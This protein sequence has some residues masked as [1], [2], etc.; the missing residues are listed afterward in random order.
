MNTPKNIRP[1]LAALAIALVPHITRLPVWVVLWCLVS[2]GYVLAAVIYNLPQ[3]GKAV[4]LALT[5][6]GILG[7]LLFREG[8]LDQ[9]SSV[10]LLWIMASI[11]PMEIRSRRDEMVIIFMT[12]F[13]AVA[14]LFF[15][16]TL[17]TAV[18]MIFSICISMAVLIR[19]HHPGGRRMDQLRLAAGLILKAMPLALILFL[20]FPRIHGSLWGMRRPTQAYSGFSDSLSPGTVTSLVRNTAIAFRVEF[21]NTIPPPEHLYWRGLVFWHFDGSA[22]HRSNSSLRISLPL[23]GSKTAAYTVT[24]EPHN[25]RW[26]FALDV[27][28]EFEASAVLMSDHTLVSRWRVR[29]RYQYRLKSYTAYTTGPIRQ[30]EAAARQLPRNTNPEAL[31]LA[32]RWRAGAADQTQ[33]IDAALAYLHNND[34]RYTLNPPPLG[35]NP[36]DDFL[37]RSRKGYC[38]HYASAFAFLMRAAGIPSRIVAGY[39]GGELNPY[40]SYLIVRQSDAHVWVEVWLPARGWIRID[41][42]LAV[43]PQ[44]VA[45][46]MAA[47]LPPEERSMLGAFSAPGPLAA[48]WTSLRFGWDAVNT[49]WNRWVLGYS[50]MR[51]K[52]LFAKFGINAGTRLGLAAAIILAVAALALIALF[53]FLNISKNPAANGDAVQKAYLSFSAK[54]TRRGFARKP[55]QGPLDYASM[56]AA[57]RPDLEACVLEIVGLY[58]RLRYARGGGRE[59]VKRLKAMVRQFDP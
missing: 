41:P 57:A 1:L 38:E 12:F 30:W 24:L 29:Q 6:A 35:E 46:G 58:I 5:V 28:Y 53:Y 22:W 36:I 23:R 13:L 17:V 40:G 8:S 14:C 31:A 4:R 51:Q 52:M 33:I 59:D 19:I 32:R 45:Q 43:A 16:G 27:P 26:L 3:P 18:Y 15:S 21:D 55:S 2:W 56:V 48:Y 49:Q 42:T 54:L 20:I 47:V 39:L 11:K 9:N 50:T 10:A 25:Q 37:F 34:F 44:R 7:V